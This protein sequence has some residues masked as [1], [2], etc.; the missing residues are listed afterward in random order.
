MYIVQ[1]KGLLG[2]KILRN[3]NKQFMGFFDCLSSFFL[4]DGMDGAI[5][6]GIPQV[7]SIEDVTVKTA[8]ECARLYKL[9][10]KRQ[11]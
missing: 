3:G 9:L 2:F 6:T 1:L 11:R 10:A 4:T 5:V 7:K 8:V